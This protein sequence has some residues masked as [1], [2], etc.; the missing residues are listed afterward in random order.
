M[1]GPVDPYLAKL[2]R[3]RL[4]HLRTTADVITY[5]EALLQEHRTVGTVT[6]TRW[7]C[8]LAMVIDHL[9]RVQNIP[10]PP[11]EVRS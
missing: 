6:P 5:L 8:S 9:W 3:D 2:A 4:G 10:A 1:T 11:S 7:S